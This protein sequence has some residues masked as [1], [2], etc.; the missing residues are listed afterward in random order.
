MKISRKK[1][2]NVSG[3][4]ESFSLPSPHTQEP[5]FPTTLQITIQS[6]VESN[7]TLSL[8]TR[9]YFQ[10]R[11]RNRIYDLIIR[12]LE[13]Y[14][15]AGGTQTELA[16]RLD[17]RADQISRWLSSPGN[18][19][20]DTISDLMLGLSGAELRMEVDYPMQKH[21]KN[22]RAP[23]WMVN[24]PGQKTLKAHSVD[25]QSARMPGAIASTVVSNPAALV[26]FT[27]AETI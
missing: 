14:K 4:G 11:L 27:V 17:R 15:T 8:G 25:V 13:N 3:N 26:T 19:T 5:T 1:E 7:G 20:L 24:R 9:V 2:R 16:T 21:A 23:E 18:L 10:E 22:S 6:E 12:Q